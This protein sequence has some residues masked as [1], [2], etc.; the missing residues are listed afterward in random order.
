MYCIGLTGSIASG[1]STASKIFINFGAEVISADAISRNI[2]DN[3]ETVIKKISA[4]FGKDIL[5]NNNRLKRENVRNIIFND[6]ISRI[7][8]ENLLHPLIRKEIELAINRSNNKFCV[9]EIP[10]L[11]SRD[12]FPYLN[13]VI[14]ISSDLETKIQRLMQRDNCSNE[15]AIQ[16]LQTQPS[17]EEYEK[18]SDSIIINNGDVIELKAKIH[19]IL[20]ELN[21][22][23]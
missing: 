5:D 6:K 21:I 11:K 12:P 18:I 23:S 17:T 10:L 8:L 15:Q 14:F 9:I 3:N 20:Q 1:K 2:T 13:H 22:F 16:I 19:K 4:K 7:W